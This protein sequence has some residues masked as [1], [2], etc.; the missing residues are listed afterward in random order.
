MLMKYI[1]QSCYDDQVNKPQEE[2][3]IVSLQR[4]RKFSSSLWALG[5]TSFMCRIGWEWF[6]SWV[7]QLWELFGKKKWKKYFQKGAHF[8]MILVKNSE[9]KKMGVKQRI[10]R[11]KRIL[12]SFPQY[13]SVWVLILH[14]VQQC[15]PNFF[16]QFDQHSQMLRKYTF[17]ASNWI[18][19]FS[20]FFPDLLF[21]IRMVKIFR[22]NFKWDG[23]N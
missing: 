12:L 8:S 14:E 4:V 15:T 17:Y 20:G 1:W 6:L 21:W 23:C 11:V 5:M 7:H 19:F 9:G 13:L 22:V 16:H 2:P 10:L 18:F 3:S